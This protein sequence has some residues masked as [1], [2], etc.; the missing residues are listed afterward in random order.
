VS[1]SQ[2]PSR[3]PIALDDH[4]ASRIGRMVDGR[5][6]FVTTPFVPAIGS[7]AG[8]AFLAVFL[9]DQAGALLEARIDDLGT[10]ANLDKAATGALVDKRVAELGPL[11]FEDIEVQPFFI[12]RFGVTFGLIPRRGDYGSG[13][14]GVWIE[15]HPGNYMAFHEPWNGAYDT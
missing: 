15:L 1:S 3:I 7:T 2:I 14:E 11:T 6:F 8:R 5:Q 9:F 4:H 10:R 12:E 13:D